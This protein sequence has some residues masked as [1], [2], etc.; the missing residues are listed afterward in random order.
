MKTKIILI[1]NLLLLSKNLYAVEKHFT[2]SNAKNLTHFANTLYNPEVD[3]FE[4]IERFNFDFNDKRRLHIRDD[5]KW[6]RKH[7]IASLTLNK[8]NFEQWSKKLIN[9]DDEITTLKYVQKCLFPKSVFMRE[10]ISNEEGELFS[11]LFLKNAQKIDQL[12]FFALK[13]NWIFVG[14]TLFA[15]HHSDCVLALQ[16]RNENVLLLQ[17]LELY[18]DL[19][20]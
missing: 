19:D 8:N 1:F 15:E 5:Y 10:I 7:F 14:S 12:K 2:Q 3:Y 13:D 4:L 18:L 6:N 20:D 17:A 9:L 16:D 11:K